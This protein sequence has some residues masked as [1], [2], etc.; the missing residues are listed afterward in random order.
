MSEM[1]KA[2]R[3]DPPATSPRSGLVPGPAANL[4]VVAAAERR[5]AGRASR[6]KA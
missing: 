4:P 1:N 3:H 6:S 5:A 2:S